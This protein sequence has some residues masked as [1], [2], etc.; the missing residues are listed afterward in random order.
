[1]FFNKSILAAGM[2]LF[3]SGVVGQLIDIHYG[4]SSSGET[5]TQQIQLKEFTE[6]DHPGDYTYFSS[7]DVC[8][9]Y[10]NDLDDAVYSD[11]K[12]TSDFDETY[13][14]YVYCYEDY[15]VIKV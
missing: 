4:Y 5:F 2:A 12:G 10:S 1:M 6:L 8:D 7:P 15:D 11:V 9:L 3:T 14:S 13:L